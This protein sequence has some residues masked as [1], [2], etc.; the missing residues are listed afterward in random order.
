MQ[1]PALKFILNFD[2]FNAIQHHGTGKI[3]HEED[4]TAFPEHKE[5]CL[6]TLAILPCG[7]N[8]GWRLCDD[9]FLCVYFKPK[10]I[11]GF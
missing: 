10:R 6:I 5:R 8:S 3:L 4:V 7:Q 9:A 11:V 2:A 1:L